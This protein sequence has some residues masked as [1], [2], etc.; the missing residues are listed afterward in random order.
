MSF[1][2]SRAWSAG[3]P[4]LLGR[5]PPF[6]SSTQQLSCVTMI[7]GFT[8]EGYLPPGVHVA[9]WEEVSKRFGTNR[10]RRHLLHGLKEALVQLRLAGCRR[11]YLDGSFVTSEPTPK[12][13]DLCY[14]LR[15]MDPLFLDPVFFDSRAG[16][17]SQKAKYN[18][19][20]FPASMTAKPGFT[21]FQFFQVDKQTGERKGI[22]AIDL[23]VQP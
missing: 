23:G 6:H 4:P 3:E 1:V 8:P 19:E 20:L 13:F 11:V 9:T 5:P 18:G 14:E 16:R 12:D 7:P 17:A 22:V 2:S 21:F 10:H 15:G